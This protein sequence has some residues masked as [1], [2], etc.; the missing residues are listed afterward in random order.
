MVQRRAKSQAQTRIDLDHQ[1]NRKAAP[2]GS[3]IEGMVET[4]APYIEGSLQTLG[5]AATKGDINAAK[6]VLDFLAKANF[7][8]A[9]KRSAP[10]LERIAQIRRGG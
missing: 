10:V 4:L 2:E 5:E 1:A 6:A 8:K 9:D 3:T 7:D